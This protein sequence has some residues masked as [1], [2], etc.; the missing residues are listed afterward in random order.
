MKKAL[1]LESISKWL[2]TASKPII[3]SGPCSAE[4]E[5]QVV[6]IAHQLK[7]SDVSVFRAGIWK[8]R[9][10]PGNFEGVG[11]LGLKWLKTAKEETG[12]LTTTEVANPNHVDLALENDIDILWIG[13]RTTVSPFIVQEI[14]DAVKQIVRSDVSEDAI[15]PELIAN[16]M[17]SP[18]IP[19]VDVIVRTS[20]EKRLSNFMLWRAAYSEFIFLD[21][22]WPDMTKEDVTAI[23]KEYSE[24]NRR[25]GG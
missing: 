25:F 11:A 22:P 3:I 8:P 14:A 1:Q 5:E 13:A 16:H 19:P 21:K 9:T 2:P 17:Y 12:L 20:G 18:E 24:R 15:T 6:K 7:D 23:L 10:R 4:T